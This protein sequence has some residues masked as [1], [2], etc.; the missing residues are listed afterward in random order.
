MASGKETFTN[1]VAQGYTFKGDTILLG[2]AMHENTV[3]PQAQVRIPLRT[4]NRHG[5]IAGATGTGKT[6]TV[7]KLAEALSEKGVASLLMDIKGDLSGIAKPGVQNERIAE[8][9]Q[10]LGVQWAAQQYPVEFLSISEEAGVRLR[11]T[12]SEFGPVLISKIL[13]LN[14]TQASVVTLLFK[15]CDD[16]GLALLDLKDFKKA[17]QYLTGEGKGEIEQLYGSISPAST[18][19]ILRKIIEL[20]Q[21]GAEA[22]FGERSFDVS[23]LLHTDQGKGTIHVLRLSDLQSKPKL[24]STF[25]LCLLAEIYEKFPEVGDPEKPKLVLF[26]DE[27]HLIFQEASK[28]LLTQ[29]ETVIKLIRSKGVGV[30]FITQNPSDVPEAVLS[31]L[32][33]KVQHALRAFTA[34]DRKAIKLAAQNYPETVFYNTEQLLTELGTGEALVSAISERGIPTPLVHTMILAPQ[35][36]MDI[37]TSE[38]ISNTVAKSHLASKYNERIDRESAYELL[39][40]KYTPK[41]DSTVPAKKKEKSVLQEIAKNPAARQFARTMAAGLARGLLGVLTR[42]K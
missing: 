28:A 14:D 29:I 6:K 34:Q 22:F 18:N 24:F 7:Q 5:L 15:Y 41:T 32:G 20:E 2:A 16:N 40:R 37:L 19:I 4:L 39:T 21:Q 3:H 10:Q 31:Q 33:L 27:A 1:A 36:R 9:H 25:M 42:R 8:R 35:S 26:I 13:E 30:L 38:E 12:V 11:A 23:D 17:L